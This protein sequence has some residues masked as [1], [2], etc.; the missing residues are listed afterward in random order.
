MG[1]C[2]EAPN[3]ERPGYTE[4]IFGIRLPAYFTK[5]RC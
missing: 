4:D 1:L 5:M 2:R 3:E